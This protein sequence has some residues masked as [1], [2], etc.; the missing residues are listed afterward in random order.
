MTVPLTL[1][2]SIWL[3]PGQ[4]VS[5]A[6]MV[7]GMLVLL[8]ACRTRMGQS[9]VGQASRLPSSPA[10]PDPRQVVRDAE[11]LLALLAEQT[12]HQAARIERLLGE[13]DVRIRKLESLAA[14]TSARVRHEPMA[15]PIN[16]QI[17]EMADEGLPPVEIA[18]RLQ[19]H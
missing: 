17:Y 9:P 12:E 8:W 6:L 11:E 4:W 19:Q 13:A 7:G 2:D 3:S 16:S 10:D 15:D 14:T 18:R 1:A 5:V